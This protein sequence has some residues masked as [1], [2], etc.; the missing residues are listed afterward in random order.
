MAKS[1]K[2]WQEFFREKS[3]R[4][5]ASVSSQE[6]MNLAD[7][8]TRVLGVF[9]VTDESSLKRAIEIMVMAGDAFVTTPCQTPDVSF[10]N[11]QLPE[12]VVQHANQEIKS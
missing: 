11:T 7:T 5:G 6:C 9:E 2:E 12:S 1:I 8:L 10:G 4:M 3:F